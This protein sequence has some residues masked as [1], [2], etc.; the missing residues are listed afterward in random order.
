MLVG[1]LLAS[2]SNTPFA[3]APAFL[4]A[5][6]VTFAVC[7]R[8][9]SGLE[10]HPES[11]SMA[12]GSMRTQ[13]FIENEMLPAGKIA[14]CVQLLF[15][16]S[17]RAF[18]AP[19]QPIYNPLMAA[20][21]LSRLI[22]TGFMGAGKTTVGAILARDLGWRFVDLDDVVE[23]STGLSVADIFRLHGEAAFREHERQA[24]EQLHQQDEIVLALGGG[25]IENHATRAL[26]LQSPSNCLVFLDAPLPELLARCTVEGKVRPLLM[27]AMTEESPEMRHHRRL[28]YYRSAH[29]TVRTTGLTPQGVADQVLAQVAQQYSL[30][31]RGS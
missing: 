22:L 14:Q 29:L 5:A 26:L 10:K 4:L 13:I 16:A 12:T 25:A 23:A 1:P 17:D 2:P 27:T 9:A 15:R 18:R 19:P 28:P 21:V 31:Q 8:T 30:Q 20:A 3:M 24:V 6:A 11:R 7:S